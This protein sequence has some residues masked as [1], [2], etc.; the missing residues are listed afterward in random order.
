[1]STLFLQT[2][3]SGTPPHRVLLLPGQQSRSR[4]QLVYAPISLS[5]EDARQ[6]HAT[7]AW[8]A[9]SA[10][11]STS[12]ELSSGTTRHRHREPTG[13]ILLPI[14]PGE[15]LLPIYKETV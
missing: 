2:L 8:I 10:F 15:G 11:S 3:G 5:E 13:R 6:L 14:V 7:E 1:M 4:N 12:S 9:P